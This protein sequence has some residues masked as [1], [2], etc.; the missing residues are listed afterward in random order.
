MSRPT[1]VPA[2]RQDIAQR[3]WSP[4]T[5]LLP[6]DLEDHDPEAAYVLR[7]LVDGEVEVTAMERGDKLFH[8]VYEN[9]AA[10]VAALDVLL[11]PI[12]VHSAPAAEQTEGSKRRW[13]D[14]RQ[15]MLQDLQGP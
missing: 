4:Y 10:A 3:G 2:L 8:Q 1:T 9:E 5:V 12:V 11:T 15:Q 6:E 14:I 13:K 7:P